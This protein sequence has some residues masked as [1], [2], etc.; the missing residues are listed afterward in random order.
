MRKKVKIVRLKSRDCLFNFLFSGGNGLHKNELPNE[1]KAKEV[2][3][4]LGPATANA[5]SS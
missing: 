2:F 1:L 4:N 3:H 5:L